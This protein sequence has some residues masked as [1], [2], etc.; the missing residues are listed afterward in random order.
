MRSS[1]PGDA[2][3]DG[4]V[5]F[6]DLVTLAR[7]YGQSNVTWAQG[8]FDGDGKIDFSDLVIL[9]RNYGRSA[10]LGTA[11]INASAA[12]AAPSYPLTCRALS[13][14]HVIHWR[15]RCAAALSRSSDAGRESC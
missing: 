15:F 1:R 9:A 3:A 7:S 2:D 10:D 11:A 13:G 12:L 6:A 14:T 4:K 8:D 5:D